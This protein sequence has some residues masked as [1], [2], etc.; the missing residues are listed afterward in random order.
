MYLLLVAN[1][2]LDAVYLDAAT[3]KLL[4]QLHFKPSSV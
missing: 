2:L 3:V 4:Q 1:Q